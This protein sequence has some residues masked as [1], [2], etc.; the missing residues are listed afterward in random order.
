MDL[1]K[2]GTTLGPPVHEPGP[3]SN[4]IPEKGADQKTEIQ[5]G[6]GSIRPSRR[7]Q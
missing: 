1:Y 6:A 4:P 2:S 5:W 3:G 7:T